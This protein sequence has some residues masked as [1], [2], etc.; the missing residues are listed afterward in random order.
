MTPKILVANGP[1]LDLLG[2]REVSVY[3]SASLADLEAQL[4]Q[5]AARLAPLFGFESIDLSFFQSNDES[6]MC[7]QLDRSWDGILLNPAAWTH[8]SVAIADRLLAKSHKYVEVHISNVYR[9]EDFRRHSFTAAHAV[10]VVTGAGFLGYNA[11]L[12][13]ICQKISTSTN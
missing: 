7:A 2:Q 6:A 10:C 9:R 11:G 8:T 4:K 12:Y 3:G 5:E 13:A 1:N